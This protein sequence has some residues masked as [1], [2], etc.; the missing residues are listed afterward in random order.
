LIEVVETKGIGSVDGHE[1]AMCEGSDDEITYFIYGS[2]ADAIYE[3][4][5]P[6]VLGLPYLPGSYIVRS[7]KEKIDEEDIEYLAIN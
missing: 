7:C 3:L 2:S 5:K 1:F 6:L 4:V